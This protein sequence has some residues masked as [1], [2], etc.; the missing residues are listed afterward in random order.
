M[1]TA[2][3]DTINFYTRD[4]GLHRPEVIDSP[5]TRV[6]PEDTTPPYF[7]PKLSDIETLQRICVEV[8]K[9]RHHG[10]RHAEA[11]VLQS[12]VA[13][14][15]DGW[16]KRQQYMDAVTYI[17]ANACPHVRWDGARRPR[18]LRKRISRDL[19]RTARSR[20]NRA[21]AARR[22]A[23]KKGNEKV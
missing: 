11:Q 22:V 8:L 18:W 1:A 2:T 20:R 19:G 23:E 6:T 17:M 9:H 14:L 7:L 12:V 15:P 5:F 21:E 3:M 10:N 4:F 13:G 16:G